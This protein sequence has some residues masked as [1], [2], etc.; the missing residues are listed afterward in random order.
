MSARAP[1]KEQPK[2][3]TFSSDNLKKAKEIIAKYPKGRQASAVIPLLYIAQRQQQGNWVTIA[4]MDKIADMLEMP[5]IR[6]YEVATFYTMFNLAPVGEYHIQLCRTTPCWL[7]G[8]DKIR[9]TCHKKLNIDIGETTPDGKFTL[10]EVECLGACVNA[11]VVQIND[12]FY[13]DLTPDLM[14][15]LI[16]DL[17]DGRQVEI[18]SQIGRKS[19]EP[20]GGITGLQDIVISSGKARN[21]KKSSAKKESKS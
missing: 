16:D 5:Y 20:L 7:R 19:S 2:S 3:F 8:S 15:A 9:K 14:E 11:P 10:S 13:E 12:D 21:A 4:A 6:V 18:G 1:A 17:H